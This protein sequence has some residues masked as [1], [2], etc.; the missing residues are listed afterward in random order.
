MPLGP[1]LTEALPGTE[2]GGGDAELVLCAS[3]D[4][5]AVTGEPEVEN[6]MAVLLPGGTDPVY[7]E[8]DLGAHGRG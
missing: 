5:E 3:E 2:N 7:L 6:D 4:S 8:K 1:V